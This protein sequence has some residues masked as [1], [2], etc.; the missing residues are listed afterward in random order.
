MQWLHLYPHVANSMLPGNVFKVLVLPLRVAERFCLW[1]S[2]HHVCHVSHRL[3]V[4]VALYILYGETRLLAL[5]LHSFIMD[6]LCLS[7][8]R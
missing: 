7:V 3:F 6:S 5:S 1:I 4:I 2:I 8:S